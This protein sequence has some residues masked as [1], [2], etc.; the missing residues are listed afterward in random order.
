MSKFSKEAYLSIQDKVKGARELILEQIK[1]SE[2][3]GMTLYEICILFGK[4]PNEVSGR[5]SELVKREMIIDSGFR[6]NPRTQKKMTVYISVEF[7]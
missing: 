6:L 1:K 4:N 7:K 5:V 3:Y 2:R